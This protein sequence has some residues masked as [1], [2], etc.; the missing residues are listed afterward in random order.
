MEIEKVV[1]KF[2][3]TQNVGDYSNVR[4]EV[5]LMAVLDVGDDPDLA[6]AHLRETATE[7]IH[8]M[9]DD[10]LE[11]AG[12]EPKYFVG[13]LYRISYADARGVV[14]I[15]PVAA[16]L[17]EASNWQTSDLWRTYSRAPRAMRWDAAYRLGERLA[18][19]KGYQLVVCVND[20]FDAIPGLP[21]PGP[22]PAWHAKNL[23][24]NLRGLDIPE[25]HWEEIS[26]LQHVDKKYLAHLWHMNFENRPLA[27]RLEV[28]RAGVMVDNDEEE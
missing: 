11:L 10:E 5:E 22:E 21:D 4:P 7:L 14:V 3:V 2:G 16:K 25:S 23:Q 17:P 13:E 26:V 28:I 9:V 18:L 8:G 6:I 24:S 1:I 15:C 12:S 27:Q 19:E 20:G